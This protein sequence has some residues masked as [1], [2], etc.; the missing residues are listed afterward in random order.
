MVTSNDRREQGEGLSASWQTFT[1]PMGQIQFPT[2][3]MTLDSHTK[4]G[5]SHAAH[6]HKDYYRHDKT[7]ATQQ[8]QRASAL[9]NPAKLLLTP[10]RST[11]NR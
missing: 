6:I 3:V 11:P 1:I 2:V 9:H 4:L 5:F 8:I 7:Y 10:A